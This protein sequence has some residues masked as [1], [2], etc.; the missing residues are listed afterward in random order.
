MN[1]TAPLRPLCL[2]GIDGE[3]LTFYCIL[4]HLFYDICDLSTNSFSGHLK[5]FV[6][7]DIEGHKHKKVVDI[8]IIIIIIIIIMYLSW[9]W[10]TC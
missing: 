10:A 1:G 6:T 9:S 4:P 8:I 7:S 5:Y 2:Y 3:N